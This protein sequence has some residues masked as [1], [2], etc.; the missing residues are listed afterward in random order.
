MT[1][2]SKR[3]GKRGELA[4]VRKAG[5]YGYNLHRTAQFMGK[6]GQAGDVEGLEGIH[7]EVKFVEK[8]NIRDAMAQAVRDCNA[9]NKGNI[10]IVAHKKN[11]CD[12][13]VTMTVD[14]FFKMYSSYLTDL[15]ETEI[16]RKGGKN[17][18]GGA[19]DGKEK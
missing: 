11:N 14:G 19:V 6:T 8:L 15:I 1:I 10:P 18:D 17:A 9:E 4:F 16:I 7:I 5:E 2:N 13:L 3:K 12:W